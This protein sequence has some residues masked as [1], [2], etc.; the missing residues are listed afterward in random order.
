VLAVGAVAD[1][2]VFDPATVTDNATYPDP[3]LP[4]DGIEHVLVAGVHSVAGGEL[5]G[6]FAG[7]VL[8]AR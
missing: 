1:V 6:R 3:L 8:R 7:Q 4:P 5:T 2:V